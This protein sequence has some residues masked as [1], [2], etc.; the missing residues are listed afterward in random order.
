MTVLYS[1]TFVVSIFLFFLLLLNVVFFKAKFDVYPNYHYYYHHY[2]LFIMF[3]KAKFNIH[4]NFSNKLLLP[5]HE[6]ETEREIIKWLVTVIKLP[7]RKHESACVTITVSP[8]QW[9][10]PARQ[11]KWG[12]LCIIWHVR[13]LADWLVGS[14]YTHTHTRTDRHIHTHTQFNVGFH[15][16]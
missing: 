12:E 15:S 10:E 4:P 6:K 2:L 9:G 11:V 8:C 5:W 16:P 13:T 1:D 7:W 3:F 14:L